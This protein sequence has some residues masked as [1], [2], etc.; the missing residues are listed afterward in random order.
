ME[1]VD[2]ARKR[3]YTTISFKQSIPSK[4]GE[5]TELQKKM[6]LALR[7]RIA[8]NRPEAFVRYMKKEG[9]EAIEKQYKD[10]VSLAKRHKLGELVHKMFVPIMFD[11][12]EIIVSNDDVCL[13]FPNYVGTNET[14]HNRVAFCIYIPDNEKFA[15]VISEWLAQKLTPCR[16]ISCRHCKRES[17]PRGSSAQK[18]EPCFDC[19][20]QT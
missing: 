13:A 8:K 16:G 20:P 17:C 10:F 15:D 1:L 7:R 14:F 2:K 5:E 11:C 3:L 19:K 4:L 6:R 9:N 18:I 12:L